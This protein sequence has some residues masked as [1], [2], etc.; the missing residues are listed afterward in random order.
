MKKKWLYLLT[1][2]FAASL[3]SCELDNIDAPSAR[4]EGNVVYEGE[5]LNVRSNSA[6]LELWQDGYALNEFI[7]VFIAQDGSY[8]ASLFNGE[9]KL[10]RKGG[11]P[12]LPQLNDTIIVQVNGNTLLD[13][14]V[15]PYFTIKNEA[16]SVSGNT[17]NATFDVNQIVDSSFL[18]EVVIVLGE[19]VLVDEN[20]QDA[21][22]SYSADTINIDSSTSLSIEIPENMRDLEYLF[23]RTAL[24]SN[25]SNEYIYTN[26]YRLEL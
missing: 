14:P 3:V 15:T 19:S 23:I 13:V 4:L 21:I 6:Q 20:I 9:Y 2:T 25:S 26:S 24:K 17:I 22:A 18:Q 8:S 10:V 7:P 1:L 16:Y 5:N 11:D 12:W